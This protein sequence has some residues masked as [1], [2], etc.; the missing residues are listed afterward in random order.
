MT[1]LVYFLDF[2]GLLTG[3][4]TY[5]LAIVVIALFWFFVGRSR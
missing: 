1:V 2:F 4:Q 3:I 5:I